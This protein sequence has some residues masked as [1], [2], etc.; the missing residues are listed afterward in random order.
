MR[1]CLCVCA[2]VTP[3]MQCY[4]VPKVGP[5]ADRTKG[6]TLDV[7]PVPLDKL[8]EVSFVK[9][10]R[11]VGACAVKALLELPYRPRTRIWS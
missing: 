5:R 8:Y 1:L 7:Q 6:L 3:C 2:Q 10:L 11:V 4:S 9:T